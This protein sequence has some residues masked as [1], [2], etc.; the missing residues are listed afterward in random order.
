MPRRASLFS[1]LTSAA[2]VSS[3]GAAAD[4]FTAGASGIGDL[5]SDAW[6][7]ASTFITAV[8]DGHVDAAE[9]VELADEASDALHTIGDLAV[10]QRYPVARMIVRALAAMVQSVGYDLADIAGQAGST[11]AGG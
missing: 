3:I 11:T 6:S 8:K 7:L 5:L 2:D 1:D 4:V 9:A 10:V